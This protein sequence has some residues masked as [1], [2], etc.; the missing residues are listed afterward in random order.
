M[1]DDSAPGD[2]DDGSPANARQSP[3]PDELLPRHELPPK[4]RRRLRPPQRLTHVRGFVRGPLGPYAPVGRYPA[5]VSQ[6]P[7]RIASTTWG[8][9]QRERRGLLSPL[10][11][12]R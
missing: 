2:R 12:P 9:D 10:T 8:S 4:H 1:A 3:I 5:F 7:L 11:N 6:E